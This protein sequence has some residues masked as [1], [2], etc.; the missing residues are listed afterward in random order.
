MI[1]KWLSK[2]PNPETDVSE[3]IFRLNTTFGIT[4]IV[5]M[6]V[7]GLLIGESIRSLMMLA[8][9]LL[10]LGTVSYLALKFN[11]LNMGSVIISFFILLVVLPVTFFSSGGMYG[12]TPVWFVFCAVYVCMSVRGKLMAVFL[13]METTVAFICYYIAYKRPEVIVE[14]TLY[15]A[16]MD[17][18]SAIVIVSF[19]VCLLIFYQRLLY[20]QENEK[21]RQKQKEIE[22]LS[23]SQNLF[24]SSMSHEIRTPINTI[25]GLNEMMLR[26]DISEEAADDAR[27][28]QGA[29]KMLLTI[30]NDLIDM[31]K[32]ESGKMEIVPVKYHV[33]DMLS[34]LVA[35]IWLRAKEKG[36]E[37][38]VDVDP[39][40]PAILY[41]DEVRLKQIIVNLLNNAVKYTNEGV[42]TLSM[43]A[44]KGEQNQVM[45]TIA[46][47]D[48][49]IGIKKDSI[50]FLFEA[51]KRVDEENN[52]YIEG[53]G[54]GLSI[55][56]QLVS[57]MGG[58]I[59]VNSVYTKGST[60]KVIIPQGIVDS[61]ALGELDLDN[62][63]SIRE[64]EHY[65]QS[66]E[67]P[68]ANLLIVD[69]NEVNLM[70]EEKL[71][72]DTKIN[73]DTAISGAECLKLSLTKKYD[74]I[75]M[76][77]LMPEMDGI[78][79]LNALRSQQGGL[80]RET[81]VVVL[82]A[83]AGGEN[84][85]LYSK[86]GFDDYLSKPVRGIDMERILVKMLPRE[87]VNL[88]D[89]SKI[90]GDD[91]GIISEHKVWVPVRVTTDSVCDLP[92]DIIDEY[93]IP[94]LSYRV[95]TEHGV[96]LDNIEIETD[97][98]LSYLEERK[99]Y[100]KSKSPEVADYEKFFAAQLSDARHIIHI[101]MAS[102][103]SD[104]YRHA[105]EAAASFDNVTVID[106]CHL[107]SGMG[108]L[109]MYAAKIVQKDI[110]VEEMVKSINARIKNIRTSFVVDNT[111]YL[112]G[113]GRINSQI[114]SICKVLMLHPVIALKKSSMKVSTVIMGNRETMR[115]RYLNR[116]LR[117]P[118]LIE[119]DTIFITYAGLSEEELDTI[120][121]MVQKKVK[122]DRIIHQK[123]SSA[124]STNCGP[125]SFG[126]IFTMKG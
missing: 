95:N 42:I 56:K 5:V 1:R 34:E 4:A 51:F 49:G 35:M 97:E 58:E 46:V 9:A 68:N 2:I 67:A 88:T 53:T 93:N 76:D 113:S 112:A 55:V 28:I 44:A 13:V 15:S 94:V 21:A 110:P 27:N 85:A 48:T 108:L 107:S 60:F 24:F 17:S 101:S 32:L 54:L 14:R 115:R 79:C 83:N 10:L 23:H 118:G 47:A 12:G 65:R 81:P 36:L 57:L 63:Q 16:Y 126:I 78:E 92:D 59:S 125:G 96:F 114:D 117:Y 18:L 119:G 30:I 102:N 91:T 109:V 69:D 7:F 73:I 38:H 50:P 123:A 39:T 61:S 116:T 90:E 84:Q 20:R 6:I 77:H 11:R 64:R 89:M 66:F 25:I 41:G 75:F 86:S 111:S 122:A 40:I 45:L 74:V 22:E 82:T 106:S 37:F 87:L 98:V 62:R 80:N 105:L 99:T 71:L 19:L 103:A 124:I 29:S 100:A 72:R 33:G 31:S 120:S 8:V 3:K 104:G 121:E 26:E 52:R 43:R 70:V